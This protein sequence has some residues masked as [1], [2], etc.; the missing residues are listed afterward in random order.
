MPGLGGGKFT[1]LC[2]VESNM[3]SS[4]SPLTGPPSGREVVLRVEIVFLVLGCHQA[5]PLG[6]AERLHCLLEGMLDLRRDAGHLVGFVGR[7]LLMGQVFMCM[8]MCGCMNVCL[9]VGMCV[10]MYGCI[11]VG[12]LV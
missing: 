12:V 3:K 10:W 4:R 9:C 5:P 2:W 8:F 11:T 7:G 1:Q 6:G